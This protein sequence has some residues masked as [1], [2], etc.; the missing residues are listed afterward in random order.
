MVELRLSK[1]T[2]IV[3]FFTGL[4]DEFVAELALVGILVT[5]IAEATSSVFELIDFLAV[6]NVA[7][8]ALKICMITRQREASLG[9]VLKIAA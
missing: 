6:T 8:V 9:V 4:S 3:A 2:C 7:L 1:V 5:R